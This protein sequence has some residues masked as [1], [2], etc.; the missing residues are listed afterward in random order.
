MD[1]VNDWKDYQFSEKENDV[2]DDE[3]DEKMPSPS[4]KV[5]C[6]LHGCGRTIWSRGMCYRHAHENKLVSIGDTSSDGEDDGYTYTVRVPM[7]TIGTQ[8]DDVPLVSDS[9]G[10]YAA[11]IASDSSSSSI[12]NTMQ[13]R[14]LPKDDTIVD[15]NSSS[16][17]PDV[18][19]ESGFSRVPPPAAARADKSIK[20]KQRLSNIEEVANETET[21]Q[22][23]DIT[24]ILRN[25]NECTPHINDVLLVAGHHSHL[26]N[27][28]FFNAVSMCDV[29]FSEVPECF[30]AALK[31]LSPPGR[32]LVKAV[33]DGEWKEISHDLAPSIIPLIMDHHKLNSAHLYQR[34]SF[35]F[36]A[37]VE[38]KIQST[39]GGRPMVAKAPTLPAA[40]MP[41]T[42]AT[43]QTPAVSH[44]ATLTNGEGLGANTTAAVTNRC[45][46]QTLQTFSIWNDENWRNKMLAAFGVDT[47]QLVQNS[48]S[49]NKLSPEALSQIL[50][51][52]NLSA[53]TLL[54][55]VF[56][57]EVKSLVKS[58]DRMV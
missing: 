21:D 5:G 52:S 55:F 13:A 4:R 56:D 10:H 51:Q 16:S 53:Q 47:A 7:R 44:L 36:L 18:T 24:N 22:E 1:T 14:G 43:A 50:E 38:R 57:A 11:S 20:L 27:V 40:S 33:S 37:R 48:T 26:G 45:V 17:D 32:F 12:D 6:S 15:E 41:T 46:A 19:L 31:S 49:L 39:F 30:L 2:S 34:E 29:D 42:A 3:T 35:S 54:T 9:S 8:T 23:S 58:H 28:Q 25:P